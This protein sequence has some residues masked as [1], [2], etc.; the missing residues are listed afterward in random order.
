MLP[1]A[2]DVL[3]L[4]WMDFFFERYL[5]GH[6]SILR[7]STDYMVLETYYLILNIHRLKSYLHRVVQVYDFLLR[8][9]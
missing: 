8:L 6:A 5:D 2:S 3:L 9:H 7:M 1:V 4:I